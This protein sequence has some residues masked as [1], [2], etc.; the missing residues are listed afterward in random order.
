MRRCPVRRTAM[1]GVGC[2]DARYCVRRCPVLCAAI[3]QVSERAWSR[4]ASVLVVRAACTLSSPTGSTIRR[5]RKQNATQVSGSLTSENMKVR[6][7]ARQNV[8]L[9]GS[10]GARRWYARN[11][12]GSGIRT[13]GDGLRHD[14]FQDRSLRPLGHPSKH[15]Q[16]SGLV[17]ASA[18]CRPWRPRRGINRGNLVA[19]H[20]LASAG[21]R[22]AT[23]GR[24][25]G[26]WSNRA[27]H[28]R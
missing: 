13:H 2:G 8:P 11:G 25:S 19:A 4:F 28:A 26:Y 1:P 7:G 9:L 12:G 16:G 15:A 14:G 10:R 20:V 22:P 6:R 18:G 5:E 23:T 27:F 21:C 24:R 3:R 17:F